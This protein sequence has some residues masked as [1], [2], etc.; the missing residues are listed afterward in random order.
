MIIMVKELVN[1]LKKLNQNKF[2]VVRNIE[3]DEQYAIES[4]DLHLEKDNY[5]YEI[6][7]GVN[8]AE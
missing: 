1:V 4:V 6:K 3:S 5:N 2:I 7:V 8:V